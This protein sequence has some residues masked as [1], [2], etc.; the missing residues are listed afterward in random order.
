MF[1][2]NKCKG[3]YY[4]TNGLFKH[5]MFIDSDKFYCYDNSNYIT[6]EQLYKIIK[7]KLSEL[8]K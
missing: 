8:Q 6:K 2:K 1:K 7:A 5:C 4:L 3:C